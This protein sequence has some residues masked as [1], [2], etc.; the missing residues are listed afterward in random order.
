MN[1]TIEETGEKKSLSIKDM[2][3][4]ENQAYKFIDLNIFIEDWSKDKDGNF[5][6]KQSEYDFWA[7]VLAK[8]ERSM[9]LMREHASLMT[10]DVYKEIWHTKAAGL[11]HF[12]QVRLD[13]IERVTTGKICA[14][15]VGIKSNGQMRIGKDT[16]IIHCYEEDGQYFIDCEGTFVLNTKRNRY[17]LPIGVAAAHI[18]GSNCVTL[19][20]AL[21]CPVNLSKT[22]ASVVYEVLF[23]AIKNELAAAGCIGVTE[24]N[25]DDEDLP[26]ET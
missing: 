13:I 5:I 4:D 11:E 2:T 20:A 25:L 10:E 1:I 3:T 6:L 8:E 21:D 15:T 14:K 7:R 24:Y 26:Q 12:T 23:T 9:M 19:D 16:T 22:Q 18:V 17:E